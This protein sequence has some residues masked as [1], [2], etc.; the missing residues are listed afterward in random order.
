MENFLIKFRVV[1]LNFL[2]VSITECLT[3][4]IINLFSQLLP[5]PYCESLEVHMVFCNYGN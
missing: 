4:K 5:L 3:S 1:L 2:F